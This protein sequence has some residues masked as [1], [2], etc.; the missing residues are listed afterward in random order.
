MRHVAFAAL[1]MVA[2]AAPSPTPGPA[3][4]CPAQS[5]VVTTQE[6]F[7]FH[8]PPAKGSK[9]SFTNHNMGDVLGDALFACADRYSLI[10]FGDSLL[11]RLSIDVDTR[12]GG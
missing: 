12:F 3:P 2:V 11:T 10:H 7:F 9:V 8:P 4:L 5:P 1:A 6:L